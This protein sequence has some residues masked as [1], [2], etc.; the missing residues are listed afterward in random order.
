MSDGEA[1]GCPRPDQA[2]TPSAFVAVL[3]ELRAWSG[4]TYRQL[5]AN[6]RAAGDFL[7]ASTIA[8]ALSRPSL[9]RREFVTAFVGACGLDQAS[10]THWV[11]V[12]DAVAVQAVAS[13]APVARR[14]GT[15]SSCVEQAAGDEAWAAPATLPADLADFTGRQAHIDDLRRWLTDRACA[16]QPTA[17]AI[18]ALAGMGGV[19]KTS[20][21]VHVAQLVAEAYPDG[22]LYVNLR[23]A[24]E[25]PLDPGLVLARFLRALGVDNRAVPEDL[26]ERAAMYRSRLAG[27]RVLV[28]LDNARSEEQIR[29]LLPGTATCAVLVTSRAR[30]T[31][32]EGARLLDLDVFSGAEASELLAMIAGEHRI[33]EQSAEAQEIVDLCGGLP[34]AVRIAGARLAARPT[35]P[36]GWVVAMLREQGRRLDHLATGDLAVRASLGLSYR[37][38]AETPRRLFRLLGLFD[39]PDFPVWLPA[40][41]LECPLDQA[42]GYAEALVDAQLL[43]VAGPDAAGQLRYRFHDLVRLYARERAAMDESDE[44]RRRAVTF[45]LGGW[46]AIAERLATRIPGPCFAEIRGPAPRPELGWAEDHFRRADPVGWFDAERVALVCAVHQACQLGLD[47][48]AF[49]LAGCLE[50]YFDLRGMYVEWIG[51]N[52]TVLETCRRAGN[53]LGEAVML[54]GL[55]DVMTWTPD[56]RDGVAMARLRTEAFRLLDMFS[57]L[58]HDPGVCD[59]AVMCSWAMIAAGEHEAAV[60]LGDRA[61]HL[62]ED[63]GHLGGRVRA[64]LVL[65]VANYEQARSAEAVRNAAAALEHARVLG[66]PRCEATALQFL[67]IGHQQLGDLETSERMLSASLAISQRYRD[68]YTEALTVLGLARVYLARG[69]PRAR[70]TAETALSLSREYSMGHHHAEA[71]EILGEIELAGG[72]PRRAIGYLEESVALWRTRGWHSYQAVALTSL[73]KAYSSVDPGAAQAAYDEAHTLFSRLGDTARA[74][75]LTRLIESGTSGP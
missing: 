20:L 53:R 69:D 15:G 23:G 22:Q 74:A 36:L 50:K 14:T 27:R 34:L 33:A 65:A 28:V 32:L 43:A 5:A 45:G 61:L 17:P 71:L 19:G 3:R 46:L 25:V 30:L 26:S 13:A 57:E 40:V 4:M 8:S 38:L 42:I 72:E 35:W 54:R 44:E 62:A 39:V 29:P 51:T 68:H 1:T 47:A 31:G 64:Y 67:G 10:V 56:A 18:V 21:A 73:G 60:A 7:P 55:I 37:W 9:P 70:S 59:A 11:Q 2:R 49:D 48:L 41:V 16:A 6:A 75:E 24:E 58:K 52:S 66:N 63:C 12:R